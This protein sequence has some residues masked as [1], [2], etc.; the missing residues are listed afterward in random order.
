MF[1]GNS[2]RNKKENSYRNKDNNKSFNPC[3]S[4]SSYF[5]DTYPSLLYLK[6]NYSTLF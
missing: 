2:D 1:R 5:F 3:K 4:V 6:I